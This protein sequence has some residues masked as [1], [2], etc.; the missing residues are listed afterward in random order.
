MY[1]NIRVL[2]SNN[3]KLKYNIQLNSIF[4]NTYILLLILGM[5]LSGFRLMWAPVV[6]KATNIYFKYVRY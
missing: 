1:Y 4:L 6:W 5:L 2:I 3:F